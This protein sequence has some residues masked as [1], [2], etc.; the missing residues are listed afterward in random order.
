MAGRLPDCLRSHRP[1]VTVMH[2]FFLKDTFAF[3]VDDVG[4][5]VP[6]RDAQISVDN[7]RLSELMIDYLIEDG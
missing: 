2:D 3:M 1:A 7:S 6:Y 5:S 4:V